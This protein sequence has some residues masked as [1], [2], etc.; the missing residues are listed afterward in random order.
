MWKRM[1]QG[2]K[3][4]NIIIASPASI[5]LEIYVSGCNR[6]SKSKKKK[7]KQ[8]FNAPDDLFPVHSVLAVLFVV[9]F[10]GQSGRLGVR[11]AHLFVDARI[12]S[13]FFKDHLLS[14]EQVNGGCCRGGHHGRRQQMSFDLSSVG[15]CIASGCTD[16]INKY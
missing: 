8:R 14:L 4:I 15:A 7:K 12:R 13:H 10:F 11:G 5:L 16:Y 9:I 2:K 3:K 6:L 1:N